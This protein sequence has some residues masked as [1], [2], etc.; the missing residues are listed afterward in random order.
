M[1]GNNTNN[2]VFRNSP[3]LDSTRN[4]SEME[5]KVLQTGNSVAEWMSVL[6][7]RDK[8]LRLHRNKQTDLATAKAVTGSNDG[9]QNGF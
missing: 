8:L 4:E 7:A 1:D 3:V 2:S 6:D 5:A 9:I